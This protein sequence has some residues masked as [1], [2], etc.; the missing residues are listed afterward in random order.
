MVPYWTFVIYITWIIT[1]NNSDAVLKDPEASKRHP[2][3]VQDISSAVLEEEEH[4]N[5][6]LVV[7]NETPIEGVR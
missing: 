6:Q 1:L 2:K 5:T 4:Q 3:L 7:E